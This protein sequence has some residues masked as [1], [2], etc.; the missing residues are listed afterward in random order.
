MRH[1]NGFTTGLLFATVIFSFGCKAKVDYSYELR[2]IDAAPSPPHCV[3]YK[4]THAVMVAHH[5]SPAEQRWIFSM[6]ARLRPQDR[7]NARWDKIT[8]GAYPQ[9]PGP[10]YL[11][12]YVKLG[13]AGSIVVAVQRYPSGLVDTTYW[14]RDGNHEIFNHCQEQVILV[15]PG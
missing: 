5:L 3:D 11:V 13:G 15:P 4:A 10:P 9:T 7:A 8:D 2:T 12:V 6:V 14:T 1:V